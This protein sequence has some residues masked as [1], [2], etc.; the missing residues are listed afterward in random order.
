MQHYIV[1][2]YTIDNLLNWVSSGEIAI[3]EIQR[4]F[5]WKKS[6]VRDLMDSLYRGYPVGYVISWQNPNVRLKD[7]SMSGGKKILIDGQQRVTALRAALLGERVLNKKF[8]QRRI[9]IAF[10]PR[11]EEFKV[12]NAS[13]QRDP[14]FVS[15]L[16]EVIGADSFDVISDYLESN[17]GCDRSAVKAALQRLFSIRQKQIGMIELAA[18][19]DIE[20]VTDIFIRINSK[21]VVLNQADFAMSK[22]A[23]DERHGGA[24]LRKAIDYFSNLAVNPEFARIIEDNDPTF[25]ATTYYQKMRWLAGEKEDIYDPGYTDVLR[26]AYAL[27]FHRAVLS[28]LVSR[29]SGRNPETRTYEDAIAEDAFARLDD[30]VLRVFSETQFKRFVM[31]VKSAGF[32]NPGLIRSQ[33]ALNFAYYLYLL[34][35]QRGIS[36]AD[37]Q[38]T[39]RRWLAMSIL[40]TR[41]TGS[42]ESQFDRDMRAIKDRSVSDYLAEIEASDLSDSFWKNGL[43]RLLETPSTTSPFYLCFLAAQAEL[44]YRGFLSEKITV[45]ALLEQRGDSH[46]IYPKEY[47]KRLGHRQNTYNQVGNLVFMEQSI[48][49]AIG[50]KAPSEYFTLLAAQTGVTPSDITKALGGIRDSTNLR[51][52]L[53]QN[54]IPTQLLEEELPYDEFLDHRRR[55]MAKIMRTWYGGCSG[56]CCTRVPAQVSTHPHPPRSTTITPHPPHRP[57]TPRT[58]Q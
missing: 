12:A 33:N 15:D 17:E 30:S 5:V 4:P 13:T 38:R 27:G 20:Q 22:I 19:L 41:A 23:S 58:T 39:V 36:D 47:L 37:N 49:I 6:K 16:S 11:S 55:A 29:L 18:G 44:G 26:V 52:N 51:E 50:R 40:T 25:A 43:P 8:Q 32:V 10:N 35:Y 34:Q 48:N 54:A 9:K 2:Q 7:G 3:P 57:R 53:N 1:N 42:F 31:T 45:K 56:Y 28:T 14:A 46:H 21:G 24:R